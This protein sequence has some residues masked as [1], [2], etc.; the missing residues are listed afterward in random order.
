MTSRTSLSLSEGCEQ[1]HLVEQVHSAPQK[2]KNRGTILQPALVLPA[3]AALG[4][5]LN[6]SVV[7]HL[8]KNYLIFRTTFLSDWPRQPVIRAG[9]CACTLTP[10]YTARVV[11]TVYT[12]RYTVRNAVYRSAQPAGA[13]ASIILIK[14]RRD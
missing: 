4:A 3:V 8:G 11:C 13:T 12:F 1:V 10:R 2:R 7:L 14:E 9:A 6:H 5:H